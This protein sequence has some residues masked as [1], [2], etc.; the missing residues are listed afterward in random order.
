MDAQCPIARGV[1][2][3][4]AGRRASELPGAWAPLC[5]THHAANCARPLCSLELRGFRRV[6]LVPGYEAIWPELVPYRARR[7]S[8]RQ[9]GRVGG[10]QLE[11]EG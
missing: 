2:S 10:V 11:V 3:L 7:P 5:P 4:Y 9:A 1:A 6:S 8:V